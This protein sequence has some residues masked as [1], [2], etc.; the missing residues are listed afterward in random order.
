MTENRQKSQTMDNLKINQF[1]AGLS[2]F[3]CLITLFGS[4]Y[5]HAASA[6][7]SPENK[8]QAV[9]LQYH[10]V[11]TDTPPITSISPCDFQ[12][13]MDYLSENNF[14]IL[15]LEQILNSLQNGEQ[16]PEYTAAISFDDGYLSVYTEA[17]PVLKAKN[18]PF[19]IFVT[20]GLLESNEQLYSSWRQIREMAEAGATIANHTVSHPYFLERESGVSESEWLESISDEITLAEDK[21]L[22][23]TGQSHRLLAYPY[24][25]YEPRIQALVEQLGYIGIAQHSGPINADSDFTALPRFPFSGIYV[26]MN[27]FPNKVK[28]LAFTLDNISPASP[29]TAEQSPSAELDFGG[30]IPRINQLSCFNNNDVI[31]VQ[32]LNA[33]EMRFQITTHI[34]NR[35]RR[36]RYNCTAPGDDGRYYWYSTPWVNPAIR[37]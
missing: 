11:S 14:T 16:L 32:I 12:R 28:S 25:E 37:E 8:S 18:W 31:D 1:G 36:F 10:H 35:S 34:Q 33:E 24:G 30:E 2:H 27:T 15:P 3:I 17:F 20:T 9:I 5:G 21:I 26:S 22:Q 23:E 19:T 6:Q 7:G 4:C 13:H 29:V